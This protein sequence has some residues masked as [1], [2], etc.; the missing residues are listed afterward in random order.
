MKALGGGGGRVV[1]FS[2]F[3]IYGLRSLLCAAS[4]RVLRIRFPNKTLGV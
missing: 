1:V 2:I 3:A 4:W